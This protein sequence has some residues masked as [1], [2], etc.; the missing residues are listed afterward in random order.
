MSIYFDLLNEL[1]NLIYTTPLC[2]ALLSSLVGRFGGL[3]EEL[4]IDIDGTVKKMKT[5]DL[6]RDSIFLVSSFLDGK[7]KLRWITESFLSDEK[8]KNVSVKIQNLVLDYCI[9]FQNVAADENVAE[10]QEIIVESSTCTGQK[11]KGLFSYIQ[12]SGR[13]RKVIDPFQYI[14][15]EISL[16]S[17]D[18]GLDSMLVFSKV[19]YI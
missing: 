6:Y 11:R 16:F 15:D 17:E 13:K 19:I 9:V 4:N 2:K 5:Y 7:F 3:L 14:R 8:K 1:A 10:T 18:D 12:N